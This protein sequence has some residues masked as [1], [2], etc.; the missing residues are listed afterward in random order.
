MR[1]DKA[2][3]E[4]RQLG[5]LSEQDQLIRT[6]SEE[7]ENARKAAE[8]TGGNT[9]PTHLRIA[10]QW[11]GRTMIACRCDTL[12]LPPAARDPQAQLAMMRS[13]THLLFDP[14]RPA[15]VLLA[16]NLA[17]LGGDAAETIELRPEGV[18]LHFKNTGAIISGK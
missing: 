15:N 9:T 3:Y 8:E 12:P 14:K 6:L 13:V 2:H 16:R 10:S 17:S 18:L 5:I 4:I 7:A 1:A 11:P